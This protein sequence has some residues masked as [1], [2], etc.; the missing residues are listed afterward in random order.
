M[1]GETFQHRIH[2]AQHHVAKLRHPLQPSA[3]VGS[4]CRLG[5]AGVGR[6]VDVPRQ[7]SNRALALAQFRE[8]MAI[9]LLD[10]VGQFQLTDQVAIFRMYQQ[11]LQPIGRQPA[12]GVIVELA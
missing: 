3:H 6:W 8:A 9:A 5:A 1:H 2:H 4:Q 11:L 7:A 10:V 12:S